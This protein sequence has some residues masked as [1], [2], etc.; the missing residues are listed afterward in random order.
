ML[1]RLLRVLRVLRVLLLPPLPLPLLWQKWKWK[2]KSQS[3]TRRVLLLPPLLLRD[4][5]WPIDCCTPLEQRFDASRMPASSRPV[6]CRAS[7]AVL[8]G[9]VPVNIH[10]GQ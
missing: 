3:L 4:V 10:E 6:Q 2:W 1:L 5:F 9:G 7:R 8:A